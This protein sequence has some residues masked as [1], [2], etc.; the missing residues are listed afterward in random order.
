MRRHPTTEILPTF[1]CGALSNIACDNVGNK[2]RAG[3][4]GA[5]EFTLAAMRAHAGSDKVQTQ[6]CQ[7]LRDMLDCGGDAGNVTR[8][9]NAG[10]VEVVEAALRGHTVGRRSH[11][12]R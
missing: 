8:A 3:N 2:I 4:A 5:V 1:A 9:M 11:Q 10:A 12:A 6:A 7:A